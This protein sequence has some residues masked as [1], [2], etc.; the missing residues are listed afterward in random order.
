MSLKVSVI[1]P[2]FNQGR[3]IEDCIQS[4]Q[5]QTYQNI[6][7]IVIDN[8][9]SDCT[10][11]ILKKYE[12]AYNLIWIAEQD[13]GQAQAINKGLDIASGDIVCWLNTDD[14]FFDKTIIERIVRVFDENPS[15]GVIFGDGYMV[16]ACGGI[17][18][19][20]ILKP[21]RLN[22]A[23]MRLA[24]YVF[25]PSCF[26]KR[27]DLRLDEGYHYVFDWL[28]FYQMF[29]KGFTHY[30]LHGFLSCY[31]M[32]G[33]NKT[34]LDSYKRKLEIYQLEKDLLGAW[35]PITIWFYA[36]SLL[37]LSS[38]RYNIPFLKKLVKRV[39]RVLRIVTGL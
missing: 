9:S 32:Y 28:F 19:P 39:T 21:E 24:D 4:V 7:H 23:S 27:N 5:T 26:W 14:Y 11:E 16:D 15:L 33:E 38:E 2:S 36:V 10:L 12:T 20:F 30:Y 37:Y 35:H 34:S 13:S 8:L 6:Q 1:T 31:R 18:R 3:Y 29:E 17:I 25:Q 22:Q